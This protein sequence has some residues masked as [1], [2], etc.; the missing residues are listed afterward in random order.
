MLIYLATSW[1]SWPLFCRSGY[2]SKI[3]N[4][5]PIKRRTI[6]LIKQTHVRPPNKT[7]HCA[8]IITSKQIFNG[9]VSFP[10]TVHRAAQNWP[11]IEWSRQTEP[12]TVWKEEKLRVEKNILTIS[13]LAGKFRLHELREIYNNWIVGGYQFR[14]L[15]R[16]RGQ[17]W[18]EMLPARRGSMSSSGADSRRSSVGLEDY[19]KSR[20]PS[21][22]R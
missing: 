15:F 19:L 11:F 6:Y 13:T 3:P 10:Y 7:S 18:S 17:I 14:C 21:T 22:Q 1:S 9:L 4:K 12:I 2:Y 8:V 5:P 16:P 20:R